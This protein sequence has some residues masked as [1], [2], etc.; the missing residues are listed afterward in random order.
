MKKEIVTFNTPTPDGHT[1][2]FFY[3]PENA[4][5]VIDLVHRNNKGGTELLRTTLNS[6]MLSH[7]K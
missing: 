1:L 7:I 3:N 5:V 4:L 2:S 6:G